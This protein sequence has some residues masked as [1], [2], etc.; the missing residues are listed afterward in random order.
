MSPVKRIT[1]VFNSS[2]FLIISFA[3]SHKISDNA[4]IPNISFSF[5]TIIFALPSLF[6]YFNV[7]FNPL[8]FILFSF[9]KFKFPQ[10]ISSYDFRFYSFS[11]YHLESSQSSNFIL[12]SSVYFIN[13]LASGCSLLF[14][15][16]AVILSNCSLLKS[17][18]SHLILLNLHMLMFLF[19]QM[20]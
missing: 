15:Q 18:L 17:Y 4:I 13:A 6:K 14:S 2:K 7:S 1:L 20:L 8:V 12:F 11:K 16:L 19:Y 9:M 5:A 10:N 3:S